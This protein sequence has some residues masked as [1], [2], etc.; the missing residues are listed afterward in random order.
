MMLFGRLGTNVAVR[1]F[2]GPLCEIPP[3]LVAADT[4]SSPAAGER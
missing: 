3:F 4:F 1:V 2:F